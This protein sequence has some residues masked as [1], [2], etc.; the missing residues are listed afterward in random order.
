M[1]PKQL[2]PSGWKVRQTFSLLAVQADL[3]CEFLLSKACFE[4]MME[5]MH[6]FAFTLSLS[7][8]SW[9]EGASCHEAMCVHLVAQLYNWDIKCVFLICSKAC[10]H[11]YDWWKELIEVGFLLQYSSYS[12]ETRQHWYLLCA[13]AVA[14]PYLQGG[15]Q[16]T[17]PTWVIP[18]AF[19]LLPPFPAHGYTTRLWIPVC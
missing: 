4:L 11:E 8:P 13:G 19:C 10:I 16:R 15:A 5:K 6:V 1:F 3:Q 2:N 7:E 12:T 18:W 14:G 9:S 17:W